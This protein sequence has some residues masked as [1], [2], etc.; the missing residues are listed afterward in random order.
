MTLQIHPTITKVAV[1]GAGT[2]GVAIAQHFLMKN[3]QVVLLDLQQTD[4]DRGEKIIATS[5]QEAV[6]RGILSAEKKAL[7]LTNL[8]GATSYQ[9]LCDRQLVVEAVFE[10]MPV[11]QS[12][13]R[14]VEAVVSDKCIIASNTSSFSIS[15]LAEGLIRPDRFLGVH[16]F[17][18]AAKNKLIELIPGT[19]TS[20]T[21]IQLLNHFYFNNDKTPIVVAD[22]Y[23]FAI[24][25][26][27]V[28]WLNEAVRLMEEGLGSIEFIDQVA[29]DVFKVGMG[30]FALMNATGVPITLHAA[31]TLQENFGN[32]YAPSQALVDQVE[33]KQNWDL[34]TPNPNSTDDYEIVAQRLLAMSLGVAAQMVSEGVTG[35]TETDLGARLGLR[36]PAGPFE[37]INQRGI[38]A[39]ASVIESVFTGY[40]LPLPSIFNSHNDQT[41]FNI[42]HVKAHIIGNTGVLEIN[43]SDTMNAINPALIKSL[44]DAFSELDSNPEISDIIVFGRGKAFVAGA[45][46]NYFVENIEANNIA[47]I[48][49][50]AGYASSVFDKISHSSKKT[51][52]YLDGLTL[53]GGLE[54]ALAVDYRIGTRHLRLGFPETGIGIYPGLGG[55]QRTPRLIGKGLA[56]FL[57]ATGNIVD[58]DTALDFGCI[59][60]IVEPTNDINV[61][62]SLVAFEPK[63]PINQSEKTREIENTFAQ[64]SGDF[65]CQLLSSPAFKSYEKSLRKKAPLALKKALSLV[66]EGSLQ[67][68]EQAMQIELAG[69]IE[70]FSTDDAY[71]GLW[72][73]TSATPVLFKAK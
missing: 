58:V 28:P 73:M 8:T 20:N 33:K 54:L 51:F 38:A 69:L 53:G 16:Y 14:R 22:T 18:H 12:V 32:A 11:K 5:L 46:V 10:N 34:T 40:D 67:S 70:I 61:I 63:A 2:M 6:Q 50:F 24:N 48:H 15:E 36:W 27:F 37:L 56:K 62:A 9:A 47:A 30:P 26:F 59:D 52:A 19:Q 45:D 43:R 25:R 3:L 64:Y 1:V 23:G 13:F 71:A 57:L 17:Y 31:L 39:T 55:T 44:D 66:D 29:I 65:D 4:V 42:K 60:G 7:Y 72:G 68:L 41:K 49:D 21:N 35:V